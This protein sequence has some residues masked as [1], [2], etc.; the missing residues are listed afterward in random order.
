MSRSLAFPS[1]KV[2]QLGQLQQVLRSRSTPASLRQR[3][4]LIWLL[5]GGASLSEAS[6]WVGLHYTNAHLWMKRFLES[7]IAGLSDRPKSG[8]PRVYDKEVDTEIIKVAA[9]RPK[10]LGLQFTTWS[11]P[12]LQEYLGQQ[13]GLRGITRS[14]IRRRL[15]QE[16]FHFYEGQT[17]CESHDPEFESKKTKS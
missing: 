5:A 16:G 14:T 7:G 17:W 3:S 11:L 6:E 9:A 2:A 8:R 4:E 15:H 1:L 12:K 13:P 10:D